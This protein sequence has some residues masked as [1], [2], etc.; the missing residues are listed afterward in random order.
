[1]AQNY[2]ILAQNYLSSNA[3]A[4]GG[5]PY[6]PT[7]TVVYTCPAGSN[8]VIN[9]IYFCN[10]SDSN[11]NV[12]LVVRPSGDTLSNN[13]Y[14]LKDQLVERADTLMLNLNV[15]MN[16]GTIMIANNYWRAGESLHGNV[17]INVFGVE[18]TGD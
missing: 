18:V 6:P 8:T 1:M 13:H 2:K 12:D 7:D 9:T 3:P 11:A 17:S 15:T 16:A 4:P 14:I 5:P 10:Q